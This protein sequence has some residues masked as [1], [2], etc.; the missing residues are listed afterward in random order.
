MRT[1]SG[2]TLVAI[3]AILSFA[4]SLNI[5]FIS[6]Q[7]VGLVLMLT[8]IT[9]LC[10]NQR[11]TGL[12][13]RRLAALRYLLGQDAS[14]ISGKR[15]PLDD[16]LGSAAPFPSTAAATASAA[17]PRPW[18]SGETANDDIAVDDTPTSPDIRVAHRAPRDL[19]A[20][21]RTAV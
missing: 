5:G 14:M 4:I 17:A 13:E 15:V 18:Q 2:V 1:T 3:G 11:G 7:I 10:L 12:L 19:G 9:G 8:G 6:V 21:S 16:L 20:A